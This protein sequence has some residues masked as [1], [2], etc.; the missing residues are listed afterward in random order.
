MT[1]LKAIIKKMKHKSSSE[2]RKKT[3]KQTHKNFPHKEEDASSNNILYHLL[4]ITLV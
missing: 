3:R 1:K 2:K 4:H